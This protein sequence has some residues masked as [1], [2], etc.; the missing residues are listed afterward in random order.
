[1]KNILFFFMIFL[2]SNNI[3]Y[4]SFSV[5]DNVHYQV[6]ETI[7]TPNYSNSNSIWGVL[8][9]SLSIIGII[10][11]F[12]PAALGGLILHVLAITFVAIGFNKDLKGLAI[13][14]FVLSLI[15]LILFIFLII[16]SG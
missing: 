10:L 13:S 5:L 7:E 11:L 15:S 4:A 12:T 1:M 9:L 3:S 14:G 8:S 16:F 2:Y 6:E